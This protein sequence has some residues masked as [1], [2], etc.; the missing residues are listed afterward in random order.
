M[1]ARPQTLEEAAADLASWIN[2][3]KTRT[4]RDRASRYFS[5]LTGDEIEPEDAGS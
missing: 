2:L 3:G 1:I 5:P 4:D